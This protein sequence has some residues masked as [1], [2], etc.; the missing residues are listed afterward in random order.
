MTNEIM[1]NEVAISAIIGGLIALIINNIYRRYSSARKLNLIRLALLDYSSKIGIHK[2]HLYLQDL[3]TMKEC[4]TLFGNNDMQPKNTSVDDM[5]MYNSAIFKSIATGEL[6]RVAYDSDN[7]IRMLDIS[8]ATDYHREHMPYDLFVKF[9]EDV[10]KYI[11]KEKVPI[12][13][14]FSYIN[15][16]PI[17]KKLRNNTINNI[18]MISKRGKTTHNQYKKLVKHLSGNNLIWIV[19]YIKRQ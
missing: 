13:K 10:D 15:N 5:P 2:S 6:R 7:F 17:I 14:E 8:Y 16:S 1:I 9:R 19:K 4:I 18:E 11:M 3:D 12:E